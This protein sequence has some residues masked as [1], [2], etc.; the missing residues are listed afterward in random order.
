MKQEEIY[1]P[2]CLPACLVLIVTGE[3][4]QIVMQT[5]KK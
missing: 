4:K 1:L 5:Q 3:T 2:A